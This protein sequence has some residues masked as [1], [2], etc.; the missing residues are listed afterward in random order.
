MSTVEEDM[1]KCEKDAKCT[2][3][4]MK[5]CCKA[6]CLQ[7][8]RRGLSGTQLSSSGSEWPAELAGIVGGGGRD[9]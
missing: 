9:S 7:C 8:K 4:N 3:K 6:Q 5:T 1:Q 2:D